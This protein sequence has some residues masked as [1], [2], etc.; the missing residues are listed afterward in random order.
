MDEDTVKGGDFL[1]ARRTAVA[2]AEPWI[3]MDIGETVAVL[4]ECESIG[5]RGDSGMAG[6]FPADQLAQRHAFLKASVAR[7]HRIHEVV[8]VVVLEDIQMAKSI[9]WFMTY[10][11]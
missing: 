3:T 6:N 5:A 7:F 10:S 4:V 2:A 1:Q 9:I 8:P 11:F